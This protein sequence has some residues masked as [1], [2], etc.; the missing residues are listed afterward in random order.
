MRPPRRPA[1][2]NYK[3]Q[4]QCSNSPTRAITQ[5]WFL[6]SCI[7]LP[8]LVISPL[9]ASTLSS[10]GGYTLTRC[11][12]HLRAHVLRFL[13]DFSSPFC[14][15]PLS[16][17]ALPAF[18]GYALARCDHEFRADSENAGRLHFRAF[19]MRTP[20][21]PQFHRGNNGRG[22]MLAPMG[23]LHATEDFIQL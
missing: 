13:T 21:L 19:T 3:C 12:F 1:G 5:L 14:C 9:Y 8:R 22:H 7:C 18:R 6:I 2:A 17:S 15:S 11:F 23:A 4:Q 20:Q 10:V 16:T